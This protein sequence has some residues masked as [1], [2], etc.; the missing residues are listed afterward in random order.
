MKDST[1]MTIVGMFIA[2]GM[3][4]FIGFI[5][6]FSA[7]PNIELERTIEISAIVVL[8]VVIIIISILTRKVPQQKNQEVMRD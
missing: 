7:Y 1:M 2:F 3:M 4:A 8:A 5:I 6:Y